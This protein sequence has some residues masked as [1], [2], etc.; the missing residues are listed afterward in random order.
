MLLLPVKTLINID[1][2][3]NPLSLFTFDI[4]ADIP[5]KCLGI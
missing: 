2:I 3:E 5:D 1:K 4:Y